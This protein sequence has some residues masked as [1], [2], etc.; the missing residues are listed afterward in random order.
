MLLNPVSTMVSM[1]GSFWLLES[2]VEDITSNISILSSI[3]IIVL[4]GNRKN[5]VDQFLKMI[6]EF[7]TVKELSDTIFF[8]LSK[9]IQVNIVK[10]VIYR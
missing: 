6:W 3:E 7:S 8:Y 10:T 4:N 9:F 5:A 2:F 1:L